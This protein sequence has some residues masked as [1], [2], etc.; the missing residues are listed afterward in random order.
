[1]AL[2][3]RSLQVASVQEMLMPLPF[4]EKLTML[5]PPSLFY[6]RRIAEE[7]RSGEPELALL[8]KVVQRGGTA[9]DVG[10]NL[11]FF[12]YALSDIADWVVA[13]EPNPDYAFFARWMLRGR[14]EVHQLAL[15]D[16]S[17]R[18]TLYVPLSDRGMILHLAGSLKQTHSQFR[19]IKAYDVEV[20]L[21]DV[22]FVKADVEGSER[23]VLDG[24]RVTIARDRPIILLELLSGTHEDP[25]ADTA[26]ICES[27]GY[28]AFI[29]QRGEKIA[30]LPAIAALGKNTSW[31]TDIDS[32]NVLFLPR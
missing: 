4:R 28:D 9:I 7:T 1:M 23:E 5:M 14:A 20:G 8:A 11:G 19:N 27:F 32:R 13:F 31:G 2:L 12:A 29:V 6:Q 3:S 15:S 17:G 10:A 18:G 24:A 21:V 25:A 26:A 30:A 22:R 16:V